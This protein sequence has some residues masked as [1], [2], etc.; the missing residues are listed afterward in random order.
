MTEYT[1]IEGPLMGILSVDLKVDIVS[2]ACDVADFHSLRRP[3]T[4]TN[5]EYNLMKAGIDLYDAL[6][7]MVEAIKHDKAVSPDMMENAIAAIK[8][9][10]VMSEESLVSIIGCG[11]KDDINEKL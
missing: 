6:L 7:D 4:I 9:A 11:R 8:K 2:R 1:I 3:E 5:N 10:G